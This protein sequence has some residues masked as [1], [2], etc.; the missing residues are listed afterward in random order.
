MDTQNDLNTA[1]AH[2]EKHFRV[3]TMNYGLWNDGIT[4]YVEDQKAETVLAAWKKMLSDHDADILSGQEWLPYFDRSNKIPVEECL[5]SDLYPYQYATTSGHGKHLAS[6][7]VCTDYT[8]CN[9][10][11]GTKRQY[12]KAYTM[13]HGNR[14][15]LFNAHCSLETDFTINRKQ[16]FEELI[17]IMNSEERV[18][19]FGDFNAYSVEE[20]DLFQK[21]GYSLSSGGKLGA[22]D[23]WTNFDKPSSWKN[24][25][26]DNIIVSSDIRILNV[27]VDRR[28]LSDHSMLVADLAFE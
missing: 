25:A 4:K 26:I 8:V 17:R 22:F 14:V 1:H 13:I 15:C 28:D 19:L 3:A 10:S 20:F 9:F 7:T 23:T 27:F 24:K 5:F 16:E 11:T 18:I 6:K 2:E 12:T 21:A